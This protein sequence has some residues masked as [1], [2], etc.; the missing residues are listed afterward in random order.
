MTASST[1]AGATLLEGLQHWLR[2]SPYAIFLLPLSDP[3]QNEYVPA[4][5]NRL[6]VVSGFTGSRGFL[7]I[8]PKRACLFVDSRYTIQAPQQINTQHFDI[9]DYTRADIVSWI[10]ENS[11]KGAHFAYDPRL[12][13]TPFIDALEKDLA[14][15]HMQGMPLSSNPVDPLWPDRPPL[16]RDPARVFDIQYAGEGSPKKLAA[17]QAHMQQKGMD[18]FLF[19]NPL[20]VN[21]MLNIRGNDLPHTPVLLAY[22]LLTAAGKG[23]LFTD[24]TKISKQVQAHL[25]E[26]VEIHALE[27]V[28]KVLR[29]FPKIHADH[30][31]TPHSL[32]LLMQ[33][34]GG[35]LSLIPDISALARARKNRVEVDGFRN[36]HIHDGIAITR[37]LHALAAPS[38]PL[39]EITAAQ[40]LDGLRRENRACQDLSF[41]T[42]SAVGPNAALPHYSSTPQTNRPLKDA[43]YLVDSGGQYFEGTTDITRT[44][45]MGDAIPADLPR[46][47]TLVLKGHIALARAVFPHGTTGAQL[48]VLARQYLWQAGLNFGH[49]TGHGVGHYLSVHEG[50]QNISPN[51][52]NLTPLLPGMVVSNEPGLYLENHYG[53]R[54]E[55]MMVVQEAPAPEEAPQDFGPFYHFETLTL[56]PFARALIQRDLLEAEE[57]TWLNAYHKRVRTTLSPH[58]SEDQQ[59]WLKGETAPL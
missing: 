53:I 9:Q 16:P 10:Q 44:L 25:P 7:A 29:A 24:P 19:T 54:L 38:L 47:Y 2:E 23:H 15:H 12:H 39:D 28:G 45:Y 36:A 33:E 1:Q 35:Q 5:Y 40:K 41:P 55:N 8:S 6:S 56:A 14:P 57:R 42:I 46:H 26:N 13:T 37:F 32:T 27:V 49:G 34:N 43:V 52:R 18:A 50:P 22:F 59:S 3:F 30:Q 48:D 31:H 51:T 11:P 58:L 4:H 20:S 17:L 21:W